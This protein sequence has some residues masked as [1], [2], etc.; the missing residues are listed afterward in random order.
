MLLEALQTRDPDVRRRIIGV[1]TAR[2]WSHPLPEARLEA[3]E[4]VSVIRRHRP[5]WLRRFPRQD[6]VRTLEHFWTHRVWQLAKLAP[7]S[8]IAAG[9]HAVEE[10]KKEILLQ[11][12]QEMRQTIR[13]SGARLDLG[14]LL[15]DLSPMS[16]EFRAGWDGHPIDAWRLEIGAFYWHVL[17]RTPNRA[18]YTHEDLTHWDWVHP[19]VQI[20]SLASDRSS[21]NRLWYYEVDNAALAHNWIRWAV[22]WIQTTMRFSRSNPVDEQHSTYLI[23]CDVFLSSDAR[24]VRAVQ[25]A[26]RYCPVPLARAITIDADRPSTVDEIHSALHGGTAGV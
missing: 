10:R 21:F 2:M 3:N 6:R 23:D 7:E 11:T 18:W 26:A 5:G 1:M 12:A 16:D 9:R 22:K 25:T 20:E 4:V 13:D 15:A 17:V 14:R 8:L 19:W 24:F